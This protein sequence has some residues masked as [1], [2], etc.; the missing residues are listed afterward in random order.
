MSP[1]SNFACFYQCCDAAPI[2][3]PAIEQFG[4]RKLSHRMTSIKRQLAVLRLQCT[5]R[6]VLSEIEVAEHLMGR[7]GRRDRL[8]LFYDENLRFSLDPTRLFR[9]LLC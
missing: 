1:I 2:T 7:D 5:L 4:E 9:S 6:P 3:I 8:I